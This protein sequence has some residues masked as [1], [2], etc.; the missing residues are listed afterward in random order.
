MGGRR[1]EGDETKR[2]L[3]YAENRLQEPIVDW[4]RLR[5]RVWLIGTKTKKVI[6]KQYGS[7]TRLKRQMLLTS[8]LRKSGFT[9][10]CRFLEDDNDSPFQGKAFGFM[11]YI[12]EDPAGFTFGTEADIRR[13]PPVKTV[14]RKDRALSASRKNGISALFPAEKMAGAV[15]DISGKQRTNCP[16]FAGNVFCRVRKMGS[17]GVKPA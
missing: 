10:T 9:Q 5:D 1:Q 15:P 7:D 3:L 2:L 14:S 8:E 4:R 13:F 11:A 16:V 6:M 12:E 17:R